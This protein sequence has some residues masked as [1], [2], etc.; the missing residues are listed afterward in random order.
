MA[1][2]F[3]MKPSLA[4]PMTAQILQRYSIMYVKRYKRLHLQYENA[5]GDISTVWR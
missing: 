2:A 3:L 4:E 1:E 5:K